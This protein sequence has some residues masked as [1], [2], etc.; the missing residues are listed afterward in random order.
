MPTVIFQ[1]LGFSSKKKKLTKLLTK[2]TYIIIFVKKKI[3]QITKS[4]SLFD[5]SA[6]IIFYLVFS[7]YFNYKSVGYIGKYFIPSTTPDP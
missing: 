1:V 5:L 2:S 7:V 3:N 6:N 4:I